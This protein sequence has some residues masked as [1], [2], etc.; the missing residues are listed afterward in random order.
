MKR[1]DLGSKMIAGVL[2][3]AA[4]LF[5]APSPS[6]AADLTNINVELPG[7]TSCFVASG[8]QF[9]DVEAHWDTALGAG[10]TLADGQDFVFAQSGDLSLFFGFDFDTSEAALSLPSDRTGGSITLSISGVDYVFSDDP[11]LS[12][13]LFRQGVDLDGLS[14][15]VN[16]TGNWVQVGSSQPIA[17]TNLQITLFVGYADNLHTDG[18]GGSS[19]T[20]NPCFPDNF[21]DLLFPGGGAGAPSPIGQ[22]AAGWE[23]V[24]PTATPCG[25]ATD[26]VDVVN[27]W[28]SGAIRIVISAIQT[29]EPS[30]LL[31]VGTGLLGLA[32]WG[33]RRAKGQ[34]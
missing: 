3:L 29:P 8:N 21:L 11:A 30:T 28:D 14:T 1:A 9:D 13:G 10:F 34:K 18:C 26:S 20:P 5:F 25:G 12:V 27:C 33:R 32:G 4:A 31:L 2:A 7:C 6:Q 16:E 24:D 22:G 23:N 15:A 17:G 19:T